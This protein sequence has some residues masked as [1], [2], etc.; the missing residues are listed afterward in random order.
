MAEPQIQY[1]KTS[2]GVNIAYWTLGSAG[3]GR[4]LVLMP[5]QISHIQ[6][7]WQV[8]ELRTWYE[9]LA[10]GRRIVRYDGRGSGLSDLDAPDYSLSA[11]TLDLQAVVEGAGL[12]RFALWAPN[13]LGPAGIT[14]AASYPERV[15]HLILWSTYARGADAYR[16][17]EAQAWAALRDKDWKIYTETL[18][19]IFFG[20]SDS[21]RAGK[22]ATFIREATTQAAMRS[23]TAP[24]ADFD[25]TALLPGLRS[26]TLVLHQRQAVWP[27][28]G[29][30]K[31]LASR[32]SSA[33]LML[34]ESSQGPYGDSQ[35]LAKIVDEFLSEAEHLEPVLPSGT[36][37]IL[38]AD[39]AD[40]TALTE[41]LGDIAFREKARELDDAL[42]GAI[43]AN[44]GTAID[45]KL[46]GDGVLATFGAAHEA[47]ACATACHAV[48]DTY[49]L[50]LHV[51]VHAG[52]VIREDGNV[53]GGAVNIASRVASEAAAGKTLVSATVRELAR[54][55]AGASFD[56]R[57]ERE[58]KG[59]GEPVRL[60]EV[61][62]SD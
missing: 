12:E 35:A 16:S 60:Y 14:Y 50:K 61:R 20:W 51:G 27:E 24:L 5:L 40:S 29:L 47:I 59:V 48:A 8:P 17:P 18:G 52:D 39:I 42:R 11:L 2:D 32:I 25:V 44:G 3:S 4:T 53:Y 58:L 62:V 28:L 33:R 38:F 54:T 30:S 21:E 36:A 34:L 23:L 37:I 49:G 13:D 43:G 6:L 41:Q 1:A 46:L 19:H 45:G 57:G 7:E 31:E 15:T 56:D 26:P 9:R 55:S 22:F 10:E